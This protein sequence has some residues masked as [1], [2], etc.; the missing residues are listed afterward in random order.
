[1]P[2][3]DLPLKRQ[4]QSLL[5]KPW[6]LGLSGLTVLFGLWAAVAA[7]GV[8]DPL[9]LPSPWAVLAAGQQELAAGQL[10]TDIA[11]SLMRVLGGFGL[12]A[13]VALP[14][15]IAMGSNTTICRLLEPLLALLRYM[16][17]PAFIPLLIIYFGLGELPKSLLPPKRS[18][19][20]GDRSLHRAPG[21]GCL[22]DQ[23]GCCLESGDRGRTGCRRCRPW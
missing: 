13:L 22:S 17:A 16:P 12:S 7:A 4:L 15:G 23:Y 6:A 18:A 14:L 8:V 21:T 9:F 1:M 11:A 3:L 5:L 2:S 19:H 20:P 10:C